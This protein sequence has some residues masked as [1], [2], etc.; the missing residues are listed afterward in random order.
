MTSAT[1]TGHTL[2]G[3]LPPTSVP[4]LT[5]GTVNVNRKLS[6]EEAIAATGC[7]QVVEPQILSSMP[8]GREDSVEVLFVRLNK[9]MNNEQAAE[10]LR[11]NKLVAAEPLALA[12]YIAAN[13]DFA[14]NYPCFTHWQ[15]K[16]GLWCHQSFRLSLGES[17]VRVQIAQNG[18]QWPG[19]WWVSGMSVSFMM[20]PAN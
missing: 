13:P 11:E 4:K 9:W 10:F 7:K 19:D 3:A 2:V 12:A 14:K 16:A 8:S 6:A 5:G 20:K 18:H 1:I 15:G 17:K